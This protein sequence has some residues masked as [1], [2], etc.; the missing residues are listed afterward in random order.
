MH[1]LSGVKGPVHCVLTLLF[2]LAAVQEASGD[3]IRIVRGRVAK[4]HISIRLTDSRIQAIGAGKRIPLTAE[5]QSLMQKRVNLRQPR[6]TGWGVR[7]VAD[8]GDARTE[9]LRSSSRSATLDVWPFS[10]DTAV[11]TSPRTTSSSFA[12]SSPIALS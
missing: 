12:S 1:A 7:P 5:Q 3:G 6:L 8:L 11:V 9:R 2:V 10:A 4:D